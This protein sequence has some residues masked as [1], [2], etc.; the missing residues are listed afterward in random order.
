VFDKEHFFYGILGILY[1][2]VI[3]WCAKLIGKLGFLGVGG[4]VKL[5]FWAFWDVVWCFL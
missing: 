4:Q 1:G 2:Q 5:G 3:L